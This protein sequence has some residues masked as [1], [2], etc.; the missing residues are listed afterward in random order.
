MHPSVHSSIFYN[1]QDIA[2]VNSHLPINPNTDQ[3]MKYNI[4][5]AQSGLS[6]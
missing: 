3:Q 2:I 1:S 6:Y 4:Q 5:E